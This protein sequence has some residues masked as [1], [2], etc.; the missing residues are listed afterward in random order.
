MSSREGTSLMMIES[1]TS[2]YMSPGLGLPTP[3]PPSIMVS[4]GPSL[5]K[6]VSPFRVSVVGTIHELEDVDTSNSGELRR[7]FRLAD[8]AGKWIHVV[9]HGKHAESSFLRNMRRIIAYF[10][11]GRSS[12]GSVPQA[13]WLFKDSFMVPLESRPASPKIEQ[14]LW[15]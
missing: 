1:V 11:C 13:L 3:A 7:K 10:G 14:V 6:A 5:T 4:F 8:D 9:A 2:P 15:Q 12:Y